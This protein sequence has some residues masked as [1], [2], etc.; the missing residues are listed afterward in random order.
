MSEA[1]A[2][3]YRFARQLWADKQ[4]QPRDGELVYR[5]LLFNVGC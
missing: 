4:N 2:I 1:I 3:R 5:E